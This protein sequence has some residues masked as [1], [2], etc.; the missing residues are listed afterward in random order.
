MKTYKHLFEDVVTKDYIRES[1]LTAAKRKTTRE[2]VA[3]VLEDLEEHVKTLQ[4]IL[5]EEK[6]E[7][8]SHR[9]CKINEHNCGKVRE[10]I[11]PDYKYEQVVHHCIVRKIQPII[12]R[13][14]YENALGSIPNKGTHSGKK[15]IEKWIKG[16]KGKKFYILKVDV[17]H[18]FDTED[19]EVIEAK[20][21]HVIKDDRFLRLCYK[22]LE[23]EA[24][25]KSEE[26]PDDIEDWED[27]ERLSGLPL[28]FITSQWFTQL[29]FK[30]FDHVVMEDVKEEFGIDHY[31]RYADD[32]V[33]FGRNKKKLHRLREW[34]EGYL[35]TELH[36]HLKSN[37]QVFRFE[38]VD[39][40]TGKTR[41]RALDFMGFVFHYNRTTMRK[42]ILKRSTRKAHRIGKK[43]KITWYD[44]AAM[45][46]YMGWYDH[47]DTYNYFEEYI[48]PYVSIRTL[49]RI[50]SKHSRKEQKSYE[51]LVHS[52]EHDRAC[53]VRHDIQPDHS[54]PE[55]EHQEGD[56][57]SNGAGGSAGILRISGASD[58]EGR[59]SAASGRAGKP[60]HKNDYA[61]AVCNRITAGIA[62]RDGGGVRDGRDN[63][64]QQEV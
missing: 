14:L 25:L 19:V 41:G 27:I 12:L 31:I 49:K 62:G 43:D 51:R 34:M 57:G 5:I 52:T 16:Y 26:R 50:V 8:P 28:G 38:Y 48:K 40:Q 39:R 32:I 37:W 18:C 64:T 20:L 7:P 29:N 17:R 15:T 22:V 13:G 1:F 55:K 11:K 2:E 30:R 63:N 54:L 58:D 33:V 21:A 60:C 3:E 44:A 10:I 24:V 53:G 9:K 47:T 6:F 35:A 61:D 42:S 59:V 46:S 36:Q 4:Q 23:A 45:L 56:E